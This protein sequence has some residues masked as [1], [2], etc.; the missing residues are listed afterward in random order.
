MV[1]CLL[2]VSN[3]VGY[4]GLSNVSNLHVYIRFEVAKMGFTNN[5]II[6]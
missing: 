1:R 5:G 4:I 3:A 2:A 6:Q